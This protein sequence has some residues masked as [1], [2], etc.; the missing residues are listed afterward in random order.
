[1][2]LRNLSLENHNFYKEVKDSRQKLIRISTKD[3]PGR[4]GH[5][6]LKHLFRSTILQW[7]LGNTVNHLEN[8][9][10]EEKQLSR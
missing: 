7:N 3:M 10:T 9:D 8:A 4:K 2:S 5:P 6:L 1:M